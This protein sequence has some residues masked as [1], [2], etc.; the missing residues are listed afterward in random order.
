MNFIVV[1]IRL[2]GPP[3]DLGQIAL[4]MVH[5]RCTQ[6]QRLDQVWDCRD[7]L[8]AV[9]KQLIRSREDGKILALKVGCGGLGTHRAG[10]F[11]LDEVVLVRHDGH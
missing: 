5:L 8:Q 1:I 10:D 7:T 11:S 4:Q 3:D 2:S 6:S 9:K